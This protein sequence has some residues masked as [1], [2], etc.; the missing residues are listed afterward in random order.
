MVEK[1]SLL[2]LLCFDHLP[3]LRLML[4]HMV[5]A[6]LCR[7][8]REL[9]QFVAGFPPQRRLVKGGQLLQLLLGEL[10]RI[11]ANRVLLDALPGEIGGQKPLQ[12]FPLRSELADV[13]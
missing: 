2:V 7:D 5:E 13:A 1:C 11:G 8:E 6:H 4:L 10:V 12:D 3:Q 9:R